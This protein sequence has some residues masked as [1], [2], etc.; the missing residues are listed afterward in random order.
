MTEMMSDVEHAGDSKSG[1]GLDGLDGRLIDQL[2]GQAKAGGLKLTGEGGVPKQ[3]TKRLLLDRLA[4]AHP[5]V[6]MAGVDGGYKD[7]L[8]RHGA[9]RDVRVEVV[10]RVAATGFHVLLR[11]RVVERAFGWL[12]Q[13]RR[14]AG[15][16]ETHR[17][18]RSG[19]LPLLPQMSYQ[20]SCS[21]EHTAGIL[22]PTRTCPIEV[23]LVLVVRRTLTTVAF[24]FGVMAQP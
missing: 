17:L 4:V 3:L 14:L 20:P 10:K 11:R 5:T 7:S 13:H 23:Q 24:C 16:Y 22:C 1:L 6:S 21:L 19:S 18:S 8:L 15:D 9:R 12:M 2:V